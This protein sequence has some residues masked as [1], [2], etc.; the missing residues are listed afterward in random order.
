MGLSR[1]GFLSR[2]AL[3]G[4]AVAVTTDV[5]F[6]DTPLGQ[7]PGART[8]SSLPGKQMLRALRDG[9]GEYHLFGGQVATL[10]ATPAETNNEFVSATITGTMDAGLPLQVHEK[11]DKT[12]YVMN[13]RLELHLDGKAHMLTSGDYAY[14][15]A[16]TTYGYKMKSWR[17]R[18]LTWS[19]GD[20]LAN[21]YQSMGEPFTR[22]VQPADATVGISKDKLHSVESICDVKFI[23]ELPDVQPALVTSAGIPSSKSPY[24]LQEAQ[25]ERLIAADQMFTFLQTSASSDDAFF[26]VMTEGPAGTPIP[27]HYHEHHTENFF[28]LDGLMTMWVNGEEVKLYPGDYMEVPPN[29]VHSYRLD[30]PYTRFFGWLVPAVFEPFFRYIGDPYKPHTFPVEPGAFRFDRVLEHIDELD[31]NVLTVKD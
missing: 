17:T 7:L 16:G 5:V 25:G 20:G 6:A 4:A 8:G 10:L 3:G 22:P 2:A 1:R 30:S 14:I 18:F 24:V 27:W 9:E 31:L 15:P 26:A 29:T 11:T 21:F 12:I 23:G 19:I 28:C 13:G